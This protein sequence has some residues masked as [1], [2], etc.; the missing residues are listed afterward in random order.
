MA[1][2]AKAVSQLLLAAKTRGE[3][4]KPFATHNDIAVPMIPVAI[5][6]SCFGNHSA[7]TLLSHPLKAY[8]LLG[9]DGL[10]NAL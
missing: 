2:A 7:A 5:G 6:R 9:L 10:I 3:K 8:P 4:I 1:V